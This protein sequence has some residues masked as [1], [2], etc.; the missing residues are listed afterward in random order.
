MIRYRL[1]PIALAVVVLQVLR[2]T[3]AGREP[4][5][6]ELVDAVRGATA[7]TWPSLFSDATDD[8]IRAALL[9]LVERG[10]VL[11]VRDGDVP[12][13]HMADGDES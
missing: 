8:D 2:G 12:G 5:V 6:G 10:D 7:R 9:T 1:R 11:E 4:T 13:A 3:F